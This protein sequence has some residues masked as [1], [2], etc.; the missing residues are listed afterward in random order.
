MKYI[1][2]IAILLYTA[3]PANAQCPGRF[4]D[5][6]SDSF[7]V[8]RDIRFGE[9]TDVD[10]NLYTLHMDVYEPVESGSGD[11]GLRP[12]VIMLHGG[13]FTGGSKTDGE[14]RWLCEDLAR[15]GIVCA[16]FNYRT[17]SDPLSLVSEESMVKA[18]IRS[19]EDAKAGIRFLY[20]H[21]EEGNTYRIDTDHILLGGSSAGSIC[22]LHTVFMDE[23]SLL[24]P[25][26]QRWIAELGVDTPELNGN[27]G[28]PGYS[29]DVSAVINISGAVANLDF[30][31]NNTDIPLLSLHNTGDLTIPYQFGYPYFI[32]T[33]PIVAGSRAIHTRM[34]AN[35]ADSRLVTFDALNHVPHTEF[36]TGEQLFPEYDQVLDAI[37][38]FINHV[39]PCDELPTAVQGQSIYELKAYPNPAQQYILLEGLPDGTFLEYAIYDTQGKLVSEGINRAG[40]ALALPE[41]LFAN[42]RYSL[43]GK[44]SGGGLYQLAFAIMR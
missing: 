1:L 21:V 18:V 5:V 29:S 4:Q 28:N 39:I 10:G 26:W 43:F 15:Q 8:H 11:D 25:K 7:T 34:Q 31:N 6:L 33:L 42:G 37:L 2:Y 40:E 20:K 17:E 36:I 9:N 3:L 38:E 24:K 41:G 14:V 30:L 32:P 19:V 23:Y 16:S 22:A 12:L 27:S 44:A 13:S 35:D